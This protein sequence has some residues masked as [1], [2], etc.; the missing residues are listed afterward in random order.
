M[1]LLYSFMPVRHLDMFVVFCI[2][3]PVLQFTTFTFMPVQHL[4]VFCCACR[5]GVAV[6]KT[7][8][9][10]TA[11]LLLRGAIVNRTKYC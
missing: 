10:T 8:R 9:N 11:Q 4:D 7:P 1:L 3:G 5:A 2:I 6:Q